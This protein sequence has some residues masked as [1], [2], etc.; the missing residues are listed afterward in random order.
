[1][2]ITYSGRIILIIVLVSIFGKFVSME[3]LEIGF[4]LILLGR[5]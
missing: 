4:V 5:R 2:S 3:D 1:M